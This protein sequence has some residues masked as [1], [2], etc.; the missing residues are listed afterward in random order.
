MF[1]SKG[2]VL[3]LG[4]FNAR[5]GKSSDVS[6][7]VGMFGEDT[8]NSNGNLLIELLNNCDLMICNG[9]TLLC[10]PQWNR[11]QS[12]LGHKSIIDYI[13]TA[14]ALIKASSDVLVDR[15]GIGSSDHHLVWSELGRNLVRVGKEQSAFRINGE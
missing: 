9:R 3:L 1:K 4:D 8:C 10:D 5:L 15:T 2:R 12:R 6:E 7:V 13:I 11:V 14:A